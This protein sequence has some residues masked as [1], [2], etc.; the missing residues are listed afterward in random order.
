LPLKISQAA[1]SFNGV[2]EAYQMKLGRSSQ[3]SRGRADG[4]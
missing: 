3:I 2:S 1:M 4:V